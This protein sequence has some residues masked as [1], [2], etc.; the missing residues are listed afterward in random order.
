MLS[1]ISFTSTYKVNNQRPNTDNKVN[2]FKKFAQKESRT[3][4]G[5]YTVSRQET[6]RKSYPGNTDTKREETLIVFDDYDKDVEEFCKSYGIKFE[7]LYTHDLLDAR[8]VK[9]RIQDAPR[10]YQKVD[11][12]SAKL[13]EFIKTEQSNIPSLEKDYCNGLNIITRIDLLEGSN[14]PATTL[15][16]T[17]PEL[18]SNDSRTVDFVKTDD[19]TDCYTY[20]ALKDTGLNKIPMYVD[21]ITYVIGNQ[22]GLFY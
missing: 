20:F 12:D 8:K 3:V 15:R 9:L 11:V 16:I 22:S 6:I 14:I 7:K 4:F 1:P 13:E 21:N 17:P 2:I 18:Y 10:G 5:A 19:N